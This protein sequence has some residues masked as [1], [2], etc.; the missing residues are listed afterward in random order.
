MS[1]VGAIL[2]VAA[3]ATRK[4]AGGLG[5]GESRGPMHAAACTCLSGNVEDRPGRRHPCTEVVG[6][7][8]GRLTGRYD[9]LA[10]RG[11]K[12][13]CGPSVGGSM[14]SKETVQLGTEHSPAL[15]G[16]KQTGRMVHIKMN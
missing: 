2:V 3:A 14:S 13:P 10:C 8:R 9:A 5:M 1:R 4:S 15:G 16:N 11:R 7:R 12:V 6:P